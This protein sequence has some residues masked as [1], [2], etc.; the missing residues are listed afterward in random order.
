M[1]VLQAKLTRVSD[2]ISYIQLE[3]P[4]RPKKPEY[5]P[6]LTPLESFK[7]II[8][9]STKASL[10]GFLT[11]ASYELMGSTLRGSLNPKQRLPLHQ[12]TSS[13]LLAGSHLGYTKGIYALCESTLI[14]VT[15]REGTAISTLA[16]ALTGMITNKGPASHRLKVA[17]SFCLN[18]LASEVRM[19]RPLLTRIEF[20]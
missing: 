10:T 3:M 5:R 15:H 8:L 4:F 1:L 2:A 20:T 7:F 11:G 17:S 12:R 9:S 13:A 16:S 18:T 14:C 6:R 19:G